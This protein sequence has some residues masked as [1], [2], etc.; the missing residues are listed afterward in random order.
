MGSRYETDHEAGAS[1]FIE[2]MLFKGTERRPAPEDISGEIEG[3]GGVING[4]TTREVT[5]FWAK[6][7]HPHLQAALDV[8]CD[9]LRNSLFAASEME[10]ERRIIV[11]ELN[12]ALDQPDS[13]VALLI[14]RMSWPDHP[15]GRDVAGSRDN[16]SSI[17]RDQLLA[18]KEMYC[19]PQNMVVSVA[20]ATDHETVERILVGLLGDWTGALPRKYLPAP[21]PRC[22]PGLTLHTTDTEQ[23]HVVLR[24]PGLHRRHPDRFALSLMNTVLGVG[25]SSRL[26]VQ[27]RER[28]GLAYAVDSGVAFL[29]DTGILEAYAALEPSQTEATVQALVREWQR[30]R[31]E[32]VAEAEIQRA[33]EFTK[34]RLLLGLEGSMAVAGWW[35]EQELLGD[36]KLSVEEVIERIDAITVDDIQRLALQC[37][38]GDRISMAIVGPLEDEAPLRTLLNDAQ[39]S[40]PGLPDTE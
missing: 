4:Q 10:R 7:A 14:N 35:G 6:V 33:K 19:S 9:M 31:E 15:L 38:I 26:F 27:L 1:H 11:E 8:L 39:H 5:Q 3:R 36:R 22:A 17:Q 12:M 32:P 18:F 24:V 23:A 37:L 29:G 34:G 2:H 28:L 16:V 25:M 13:L 30:L 20:G 40:L 21:P